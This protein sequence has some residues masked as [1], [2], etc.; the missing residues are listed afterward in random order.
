MACTPTDVTQLVI[1]DD[2]LAANGRAL[3]AT[4]CEPSNMTPAECTARLGFANSQDTLVITGG[5]VADNDDGTWSVQFS[6]NDTDTQSLTPGR[7]DWS[8]EIVQGTTEITVAKSISY[9]TRIDWVT[10]QT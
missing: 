3:T 8:I 1:G 4:F 2:Y 7:Y 5:V 6:W 10:K 9:E